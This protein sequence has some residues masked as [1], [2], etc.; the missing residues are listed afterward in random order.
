MQCLVLVVFCARGL[1]EGDEGFAVVCV[2]GIA[3]MFHYAGLNHEGL[4]KN[5]VQLK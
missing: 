2:G 1:V 4:V 5:G 3:L